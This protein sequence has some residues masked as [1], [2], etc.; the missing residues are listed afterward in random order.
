MVKH[1]G[2]QGVGGP[3]RGL[4]GREFCVCPK[5]GY[6]IPHIKGQPCIQVK[7]PNCDIPM[8]GE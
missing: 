4:G 3:R 2:G 7:C 5:C 6:R 8:V 1:G